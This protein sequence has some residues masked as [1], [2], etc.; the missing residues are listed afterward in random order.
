MEAPHGR[1]NHTKVSLPREDEA[2]ADPQPNV[3]KH[4]STISPDDSST[5][6]WSFITSPQ[7]GAPTNPV[8]TVGSFLSNDPT[9]RG[10]L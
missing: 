3:L 8:P 4:A 7:A 6:I 5:L 10:L 1:S 2:M 9:L